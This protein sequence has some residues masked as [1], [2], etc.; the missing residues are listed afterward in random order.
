MRIVVA[1]DSFKECLRAGDVAR[2]LAEG[3]RRVF[4]NAEIDLVPMADGG[5]GTV[6]ALVNASGGRV[7]TEWTHD[8][9]GN[10]IEATFGVLGGG[11]TAVVEVAAASGLALVPM[12]LRHPGFTTSYGT[13]E[14]ILAALKQGVQRIVVGLGGSATNDA[15]AGMAQALGFS[16]RD[17][18]DRELPFGG[19]A[20]AKLDF[21]DALK[22]REAVKYAEII[23]AYDVD[24]PLCGPKGASYIYG[25]QKGGAPVTCE[26]LDAALSNF[27]D[28]VEQQDGI[29]LRDIPGAGAAGGLGA[30]LIVFCRAQL[31]PGF[32]AV[33]DACGLADRIAGADLV[34]TGEG[35]LDRQSLNGKVPVGVGRMAS[36]AKVPCWAVA[37]ICEENLDAD[38]AAEGIGG[39]VALERLAGSA[40]ESR[41]H[42]AR[43]LADAAEQVARSLKA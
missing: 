41:A 35:K 3:C 16:L 42:A 26:M 7:V 37:G 36:A 19:F 32:E 40:S 38:L 17:A 14:L 30:G 13:G 9:L 34:I 24:S 8:P 12:E 28:Y 5:E 18:N 20:L 22:V 10:P 4:P 25:P 1:P 21:I 33:A 6:D 2:A 31:R 43:Y 29:R 39:S 23:G 27:A 15:G 11:R